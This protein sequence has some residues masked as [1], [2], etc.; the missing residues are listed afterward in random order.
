MMKWADYLISAVQYN[1]QHTHI[2]TVRH[3]LD[4]G[5]NVT[6]INHFDFV[7]ASK[8]SSSISLREP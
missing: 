5:D 3:H 6:E 7:L 4:M 2:V 8:T 1:I